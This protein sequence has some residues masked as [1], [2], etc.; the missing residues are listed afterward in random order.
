MNVLVTGANGFVGQPLCEALRQHEHLVRAVVRQVGEDTRVTAIG[1][2]DEKTDWKSALLG[3]DVVI[4]LA[5]RVHVM[6]DEAADPLAEFRRINTAGTENLARA[7]AANGVK[8]FVYVSSIK[9]NGEATDAEQKFTEADLPA[10]QDPYGISKFEA[11]FALHR[12]AK[13]THLE[14]VVVRPPLVYGAGVKGNFAQMMRVLNQHIPLPLA[15]IHNQRSMIYVGNLVDALIACA[16]HVNAAGNTYL[17]SDGEDVS[18]PNLLRQL[19]LALGKSARLFPFPATLLQLLA[20]LLGK[21]EQ[22]ARVT[23]SLKV[24]SGKIRRDLGWT[25]P[26]SLQQ[27]LAITAQSQNKNN[28]I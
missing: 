23:Q 6:Q 27:G 8:R 1:E 7:A 14:I 10:P 5:A 9:V 11:E 16:T 15:A 3:I 20:K 22:V 12:V 26:F 28:S 21:G 19:G 17:L 13:E 4:H 18:T 2:I 24:D 25:P